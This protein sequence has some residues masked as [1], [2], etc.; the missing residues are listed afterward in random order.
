MREC[1]ALSLLDYQYPSGPRGF[2]WKVAAHC[3]KKGGGTNLKKKENFLTRNA[4]FLFSPSA[5]PLSRS[6]VSVLV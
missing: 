5:H 4:I 6:F 2:V 3:C 1:V